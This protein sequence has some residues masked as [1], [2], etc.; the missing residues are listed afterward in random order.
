MNQS[1]AVVGAGICGMFTGLALSRRGF[2]VTLFERDVPPPEGDAEQAFFNWQRRGAAQFRHPHAFLGLMCNLLEKNYPDLLQELLT[3]G[4]RKVGFEDMLPGHMLSQYQPEPN[5]DQL[6]VLMCRRATIETVLRRYVEREATLTIAN[7]TYVTDVL[8]EEKD[9]QPANTLTTIGLELTDRQ[10]ANK[11]SQHLADIIIDATGRA[12]KFNSWLC[13]KGAKV[14]EE[15]DDA[16]IVYYTRHYRLKPG[17]EEPK[18]DS[19]NPS[20]G[21]LG[22]LKYG[23]FP[24]DNGHFA[25]II[26]IHNDELELRQAVKEPGLFD[27]ICNSIPGVKPWISKDNADATTDP[28][29]IGQIHAVWRDYVHNDGPKLLNF[30]A[31]GDAASRTNPLYGRGCSTGTLHAHILADVLAANEDPWQ[32]AL[33]FKQ[34]TEAEISPIFDASLTEDKRGIRRANATRKGE[35]LDKAKSLK[36]WFTLAFGDALVAAARYQLHV[37]R[38]IMRTVNLVEKPGEFL[39]DPK[40]RNTIFR[41]MLRGRKRNAKARIQAGLERQEMLSMISHLTRQNAKAPLP[42]G[43]IMNRTDDAIDE[44]PLSLNA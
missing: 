3:A 1:I 43:E 20:A 8:V 10:D 2:S 22:Y 39:K 30:F 29:G 19:D 24:G 25:L 13:A 41:Y 6:W 21:D 18:R 7:T 15:R 33:A 36:K 34:R 42:A 26:C 28:F 32:R 11:K 44:Q 14:T 5:D 16:E 38:G 23:V 12:G 9:A 40:I 17:V 31:V 4:A 27:A 35:A 37:H